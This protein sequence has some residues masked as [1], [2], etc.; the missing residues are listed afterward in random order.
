MT[1]CLSV[2]TVSCL[3]FGWILCR[4][5]H[6]P[7]FITQLHI[8]LLRV[9][10]T[11]ILLLHSW[12]EPCTVTIQNGL[13]PITLFTYILFLYRFMPLFYRRAIVW[14]VFEKSVV[15]FSFSP[16]VFCCFVTA[17]CT[18]I[19]YMYD[20]A[21]F[22]YISHSC[23]VE[24]LCHDISVHIPHH[25]SQKIPSYNLRMAHDSLIKNWGKVRTPV[26][27]GICEFR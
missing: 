10:R 9:W 5:A 23:R 3:L 20:L 2:D 19:I 21:W 14:E 4:W 24:V 17:M 13:S 1:S 7:W 15:L 25:V 22:W 12:V 26:Q 11:G 6:S 27:L 18:M 8:F 16:V